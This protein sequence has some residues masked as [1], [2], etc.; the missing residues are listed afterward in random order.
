MPNWFNYLA[1]AIISLLS[2]VALFFFILTRGTLI[3]REIFSRSSH[4]TSHV[5]PIYSNIRLIQL[6]DYQP[7]IS[8]IL[9]FQ[10]NRLVSIIVSGLLK[11]NLQGKKILIT[12]CAFG[13]ILPRVVEAAI[14][15]GVQCVLITDIVKNELVHAKQKLKEFSENMVFVEDNAVDMK[16]ADNSVTVNVIFFLLHELP[17][18]LKARAIAEA[19]RVL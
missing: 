14:Q 13:N 18:H 19:G 6:V 4:E 8:A 9:L 17:H 11:T 1:T 2:S 3:A 16:Q 15:S 12:S 5:Y 10:Y 7:L